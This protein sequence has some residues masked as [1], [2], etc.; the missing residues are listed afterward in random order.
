[1]APTNLAR[2]PRPNVAVDVALLTVLPDDERPAS[3]GELAVLVQDR[4]TAPHGR[5]LPGRFLRDR[6][7]VDDA[8]DDVFSVKVGIERLAL[9]P[10]LLQ[11][12]SDPARDDRGW[13]VSVAHALTAPYE[14]VADA[15][16]TWVPVN[17]DGRLRA[18]GKLLFDHDEIV[19]IAVRR[20]RERYE[21][22]PDPDHLLGDDF[23]LGELRAVH[24]AVLGEG[25]RRDTFNRRMGEHLRPTDEQRTIGGR[26]GRV[27]ART[28][29][30]AETEVRRLRL[31][32]A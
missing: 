24:E 10:W 12:F 2:Y 32:R 13:T 20:M 25:L 26:P 18:R 14:Q 22:R 31:P 28:R 1:M 5:A 23:T 8:V 27:F 21:L 19:G 9:S 30:S 11:V 17:V 6:Q 7:S 15:Q 29:D 3:A 16:G 4:P